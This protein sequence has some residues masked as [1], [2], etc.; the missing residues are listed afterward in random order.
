MTG[1]ASDGHGGVRRSRFLRAVAGV[2]GTVL[3]AGVSLGAYYR[4][5]MHR[6]AAYVPPVFVEPPAGPRAPSA[7]LLGVRVGTTHVPAARAAMS[8]WGV[9]CADRSMRTLMG[10]L[11]DRKRE[12]V[13]LAEASGK[14]DAV[15]G[16]SIITRH[17]ARDDNPQ[18]RLSCDTDARHLADRVRSPSSGRLLMVFDSAEAPLRHVSYQR[19]LSAWDDAWKDFAGT[20]GAL[21]LRFGAPQER[22][23][24][25]AT[26]P[27]AD[28][29]PA[30]LPRY[31]R[32]DAEWRYSDLDVRVSVENLG[33]RGFVIEETMEVPWPVRA[34]AP[35]R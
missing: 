1:I 6:E 14:P 35:V 17:T 33:G 5:R 13:R 4:H 29:E 11:R 21:M 3:V 18:V 22:E 9:T 24:G 10:E 26:V 19:N 32:R 12:Q 20:R 8:A 34:D 16:A 2:V 25:V 23:S 15:S 31:A 30:P 27:A 28:E 7:E